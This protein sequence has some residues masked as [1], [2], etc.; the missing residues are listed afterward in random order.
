MAF[1]NNDPSKKICSVAMMIAGVAKATKK[2]GLREKLET[3]INQV[4][5]GSIQSTV[6][7]LGTMFPMIRA[8][9]FTFE[10]IVL[11]TLN[12]VPNV[13]MLST[14]RMNV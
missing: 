4:I 3:N 11:K 9:I 1:N 6:I 13:N 10:N 12:S 8:N 2:G 7:S 5:K 14:M